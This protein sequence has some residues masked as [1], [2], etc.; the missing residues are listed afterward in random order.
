[1]GVGAER[2][3]SGVVFVVTVLGATLYICVS[4]L[5]S[6]CCWRKDKRHRNGR[7]VPPDY[8]VC[9]PILNGNIIRNIIEM[10]TS[11]SGSGE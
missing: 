9:D 8:C 4:V 1:M 11:G 7:T 6:L 5:E 2:A 10:T 3:L